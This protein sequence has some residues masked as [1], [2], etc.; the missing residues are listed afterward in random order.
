MIVKLILYI[1]PWNWKIRITFAMVAPKIIFKFNIFVALFASNIVTFK[2]CFNI[3]CCC[4]ACEYTFL[5]YRRKRITFFV[6][7]IEN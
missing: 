1:L 4:K 6:K 5:Q 7:L 3:F 2:D